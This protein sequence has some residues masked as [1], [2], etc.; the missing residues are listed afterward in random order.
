VVLGVCGVNGFATF[1]ENYATTTHENDGRLINLPYTVSLGDNSQPAGFEP[2]T[3]FPVGTS[4]IYELGYGQGD[5]A[6]VTETWQFTNDAF[7]TANTITDVYR[8]V[9]GT[10]TIIYSQRGWRRKVSEREYIDAVRSTYQEY[11]IPPPMQFPVP[12]ES[13]CIGESVGSPCPSEENWCLNDPECSVSPYQ[14]PNGKLRPVFVAGICIFA[15]LLLVLGLFLAHRWVLARQ[16]KRFRV[17]FATRVAETISLRPSRR[18]LTPEMLGKEFAKI[19]KNL[20]EEG[21]GTGYI[22]REALWEFVS[23]GKAGEMN[24]HDFNAL[25]ASLDVDH[26]GKVDFLEFC[27]FLSSCGSEFNEARDRMLANQGQSFIRSQQNFSRAA[28]LISAS[29]SKARGLDNVEE[30]Q[31]EEE[32]DDVEPGK[33]GGAVTGVGEATV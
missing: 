2:S 27:N 30:E 14:E 22:T 15:A 8:L 26:N 16:Q 3:R 13:N 17:T 5:T 23:S 6:L 1:A 7:T 12:L 4:T 18:T 24:E 20:S 25:F 11:N 9:N 19:D 10:A 21:A 31:G 28:S 29:M 32:G 33:A